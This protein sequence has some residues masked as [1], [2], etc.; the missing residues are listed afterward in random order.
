MG[1]ELNAKLSGRTALYERF[2]LYPNLSSGGDFRAQF[3][4]TATTKLKNWLGWQITYS[5]RYITNP[6][7]GLKG[8]DQ[9]LS[10]GLRLTFGQNAPK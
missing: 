4:I 10:T 5:D 2:A 7:F 1:E 8:N 3:D 6:P 9:L